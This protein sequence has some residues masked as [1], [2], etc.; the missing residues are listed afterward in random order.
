MTE[1]ALFSVINWPCFHLTKTG[2]VSNRPRASR[3]LGLGRPPDVIRGVP[4]PC[5]G[6]GGHV[7]AHLSCDMRGSA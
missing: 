5:V 2:L 3:T 6:E 1:M 7:I 4:Y